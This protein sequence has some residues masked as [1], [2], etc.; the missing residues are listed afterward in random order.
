MAHRTSRMNSLIFEWNSKVISK[1]GDNVKGAPTSMLELKPRLNVIMK[2]TSHE[3]A[4]WK[5]DN[6]NGNSCYHYGSIFKVA[7]FSKDNIF[8]FLCFSQPTYQFLQTDSLLYQVRFITRSNK[9]DQTHELFLNIDPLSTQ[10][11]R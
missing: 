1:A 6:S 4:S 2:S 8:S 11:A 7:G 3:H 5:E 10:F 9:E